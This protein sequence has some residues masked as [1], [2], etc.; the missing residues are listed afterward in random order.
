MS[1]TKLLNQIG[2]LIDKKLQPIKGDL[3]GVKVDLKGVKGEINGVKTELKG[4]RQQLNTVEMKVEVVNKR[5]GKSEQ[6]LKQ[7]IAKSQEDTINVLSDLIHS[8]YDMHEKRI[9]NLE[10]SSSPPP[11]Q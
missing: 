6:E 10:K 5:V 9:I 8:G 2:D 3:Q 11:A 7:A 4:L 1:D